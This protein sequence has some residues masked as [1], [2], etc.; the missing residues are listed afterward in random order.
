VDS[1]LT[2]AAPAPRDRRAELML[3]AAGARH[4][5]VL[6][7]QVA[8]TGMAELPGVWHV[9]VPRT[10]GGDGWTSASGGVGRDVAGA[11]LAAVG[12]ALERYAAAT[13]PIALRSRAALAGETVLAAAEFSLFTAQQV[14]APGFA[15]AGLYGDDARYAQVFS[16]HDNAPVWVP[17]ELVGLRDSPLATSSGLAAGSSSL[18]AL[19]RGVQEVVERDAL[20]ITW[21]H[22]VPG[23]QVALPER[24]RAD[25]AALGG[26]VT[27]I[28]ATPAYS[29]HPVALVAGSVPLRGR[30][31]FSLGAACRGTWE[32][33]IEKAYLEW[34]QGVF[35]VGEY[36]AAHPALR[37]E[38]P[39]AVT[40][41]DAH[42]VYYSTAPREWERI[43]LLRGSRAPAPAPAAAEPRA[44]VAGELEHLVSHLQSNGVRLLY[45]DLTTV[46]LR[47]VGLHA[48]R[49]LSPDLT[50]IHCHPSHPFLGGRTRDVLWRYPWAR[51][52]PLHFPNPMPHPLG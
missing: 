39:D 31:R 24:L 13:C 47:Q 29:P 4:G 32:A 45:R 5:M 6:A 37:F 21:L 9:G 35:F 19:L 52:L 23:R 10:R 51:D 1:L 25:V 2:P 18:R 49:V 16:L 8:R 26:A 28:D 42:A 30:E 27:C 41:F 7:P 14:A 34:A 43:A 36:L 50:P 17:H 12:E 38:S 20:M 46:D 3:S 40:T 11:R 15:F 33:A 48:V 44:T 22:A